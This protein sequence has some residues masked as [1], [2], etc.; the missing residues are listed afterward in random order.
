M[1]DLP[2][3]TTAESAKREYEPLR[4]IEHSALPALTHRRLLAPSTVLIAVV[5]KDLR[6]LVG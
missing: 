6:C 2:E 3:T 5:V 4:I 1:N